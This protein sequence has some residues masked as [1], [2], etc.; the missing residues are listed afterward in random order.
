[1]DPTSI[2]SKLSWPRPADDG[3]S[4]N[5]MAKSLRDILKMDYKNVLSVHWGL[6]SA[7]DFKQTINEDWKWLDESTL[8]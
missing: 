4:C 3:S 1:M 8:L 7:D 6:M 5:E 2:L